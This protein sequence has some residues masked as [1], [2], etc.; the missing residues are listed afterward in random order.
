MAADNHL[1]QLAEPGLWGPD[2]SHWP[3]YDKSISTANHIG[4]NCLHIV[5]DHRVY[6]S[7]YSSSEVALILAAGT[8][9]L[10]MG[11]LKRIQSILL[12][13]QQASINL[14]MALSSL[15]C[16]SEIYYNQHAASPFLSISFPPSFIFTPLSLPFSFIALCLTAFPLLHL[17][18]LSL[19]IPVP[20]RVK[21]PPL[22]HCNWGTHTDTA[23]NKF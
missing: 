17:S 6:R 22:P 14:D 11:W 8:T 20:L 5:A 4:L 7:S 2:R 13:P 10:W 23:V 1:I 15:Y 21:H 3:T 16:Q 12:L 9:T 18:I 19:H